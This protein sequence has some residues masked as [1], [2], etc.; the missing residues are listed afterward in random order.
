HRAAG[1]NMALDDRQTLGREGEPYR[2]G[3]AG[4]EVDAREACRPLGR[5]EHSTDRLGRERLDD[6]VT[7]FRSGVDDVDRGLDR[8]IT[9]ATVD[10]MEVRIAEARV[11]E[12]EAEGKDGVVAAAAETA[13]GEEERRR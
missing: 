10:G 7:G 4:V 12:A 6:I 3:L 2:L 11:A 1:G 13:A 9:A 5:H 8:A